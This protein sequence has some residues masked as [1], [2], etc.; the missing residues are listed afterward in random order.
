MAVLPCGNQ[1]LRGVAWADCQ[2]RRQRRRAGHDELLQRG[3]VVRD[4]VV[5]HLDPSGHHSQGTLGGLQ[6]IM[7]TGS[8]QGAS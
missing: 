5:E 3:I 1:Q 6:R 7:E 4:L 2:L 8:D